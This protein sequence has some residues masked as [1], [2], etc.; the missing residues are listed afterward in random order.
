[1]NRV[2]TTSSTRPAQSPADEMTDRILT[3]SRDKVIEVLPEAV[4]E[5]MRK[6]LPDHYTP[7]AAAAIAART[8]AELR[9]PSKPQLT[10][11]VRRALAQLERDKQ[12]AKDA[13]LWDANYERIQNTLGDMFREANDVDSVLE[14]CIGGIVTSIAQDHGLR[15]VR[16]NENALQ[17]GEIVIWW[18]SALVILPLG[19]KAMDALDQLRAALAQKA[20]A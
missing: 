15:V 12:T 6:T 16:A 10:P 2:A 11:A 13:G 19:I 17:D 14:V 7:E 3:A 5:A 18:D 1:M 20:D 8:A 4:D 9:Q